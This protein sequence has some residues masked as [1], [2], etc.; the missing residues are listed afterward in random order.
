MVSQL[1][2]VGR[3]FCIGASVA[4]AAVLAMVQSSLADP[5]SGQVKD[6][7]DCTT[8]RPC[9][10][11]S[12]PNCLTEIISNPSVEKCVGGLPADNCITTEDTDICADKNACS[13]NAAGDACVTGAA[14][15]PA[16]FQIPDDEEPGCTVPS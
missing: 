5:C 15:A 16:T 9:V 6:T 10:I 11:Q 4:A 2:G 3:T 1:G 14:L 12:N 13:K 8:S 7:V